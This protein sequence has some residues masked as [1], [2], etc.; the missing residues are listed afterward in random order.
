MTRKNEAAAV[1]EPVLRVWCRSCRANRRK[2]PSH[3]G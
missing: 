1:R 3:V 2:E